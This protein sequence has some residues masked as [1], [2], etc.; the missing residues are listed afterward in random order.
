MNAEIIRNLPAE[1]Y[2]KRLGV[3]ASLLKTVHAQSLKHA[4]AQIDGLENESD[5]KDFGTA[6]HSL[7][8]EGKQD[9]VVHPETYMS[10]DKIPVAKP[11]NWNANACKAWEAAQEGKTILN[12]DGAKALDSMCAAAKDA[13]TCVELI[14]DT[15]LSV[16]AE[17]DGMPIKAR[18]DLL[19]KDENAPVIDF[20]K[21]RSAEPRKFLRQCYDLGYHIQC[22]WILDVL[23]LAGIPRDEVWLVGIEDKEPFAT[24]TLKFSDEPIS[25]LRLGRIHARAAFMKA[26]AAYESGRWPD[27]GITAA[28]NHAMPWMLQELEQTS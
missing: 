28:E 2:R 11:W 7:L 14:G 13:L 3:N 10:S 15:E 20:K 1:E 22:A 23:R 25:F 21:V 4:K 26:K 16:F 24:C 8:L 19:P 12:K 5:A 18:I 27:Y 17:K 6:F 9:F